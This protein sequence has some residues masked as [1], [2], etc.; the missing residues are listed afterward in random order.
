MDREIVNQLLGCPSDKHTRDGWRLHAP[1]AKEADLDQQVAWI[2]ARVTDDL[3]V[4][5]KVTSEYR[6]DLFVGLFLE[7]PNRG[8]ELSPQTM[9]QLGARGIRLGLD[10]YGPSP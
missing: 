10:I 8:I 9:T 7:R 2:L 4:W 1:E 6:V 3:E 5:R